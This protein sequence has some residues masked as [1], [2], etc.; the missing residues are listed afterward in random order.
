MP[1]DFTEVEKQLIIHNLEIFPHLDQIINR[2]N[3]FFRKYNASNYEHIPECERD[4]CLEFTLANI[5]KNI[6]VPSFCQRIQKLDQM[7]A[8]L[9]Q[10]SNTKFGRKLSQ[11]DFF[12]VFSE[13]EVYYHLLLRG[14][15][16]DLEPRI[17]VNGNSVDFGF[18]LR[19]KYFYIEVKTPRLSN[20][21]NDYFN[22][23]PVQDS[24]PD[25]H[26]GAGFIDEENQRFVDGTN[27]NSNP[28][29]NFRNYPRESARVEHLI[30]DDFIGGNLR[31][32]E[33]PLSI[34]IILII[35][36]ELARSSITFYYGVLEWLACMMRECPPDRIQGI[37]IYPSPMA[38]DTTSY[39]FQN[40]NYGF[41]EEEIRFFS[42]LMTHHH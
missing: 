30:F 35:N 28:D 3:I 38:L 33:N 29:I 31:T 22:S 25:L 40:S 20:Q 5:L 2:N 12:S 17:S 19:G 23:L 18:F 11:S 24:D 9:P 32:F 37:L 27:T 8:L 21:I 1:D 41:S 10:T 14:K 7:I 16:P 4:N 6:N 34:P 13:I 39:F 26:I 42:S 15:N 36:Y